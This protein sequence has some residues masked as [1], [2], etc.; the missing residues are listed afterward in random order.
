ML[1]K[2]GAE[3]KENTAKKANE[4]REKFVQLA[5]NRTRNAIKAVR[6]IAKLGNKN[7][8]EFTEADVN[9]IAKALIREIELMKAR[10]SSTGSKESVEF[11]L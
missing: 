4:K 2:T 3:S 8:Y 11:K 7:A 6:V 10:M 1:D 9:K 5:E